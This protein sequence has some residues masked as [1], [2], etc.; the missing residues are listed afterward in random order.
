[1]RPDIPVVGALGR[2]PEVGVPL[3][4]LLGFVETTTLV[5]TADVRALIAAAIAPI[6]IA[7]ILAV[8]GTAIASDFRQLGVVINFFYHDVNEF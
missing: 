6:G 2:L 1:M 5:I 8:R 3:V 7:T 4:T